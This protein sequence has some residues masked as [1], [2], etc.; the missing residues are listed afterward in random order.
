MVFDI[1]LPYSEE[2]FEDFLD[3]IHN[4]TSVPSAG[5]VCDIC[6]SLSCG[7][8]CCESPC[9]QFDD[10][11]CERVLSVLI[12]NQKNDHFDLS[13]YESSVSKKIEKFLSKEN[14]CSVS[15]PSLCRIFGACN[16]TFSLSSLKPFF[17]GCTKRHGIGAKILLHCIQYKKPSDL[18]D[19]DQF[20]Q[21]MT[22]EDSSGIS[23]NTNHFLSSFQR[24]FESL[25]IENQRNMESNQKT[26]NELNNRIQ[27]HKSEILSSK[28]AINE[29]NKE[30]Q[31]RDSII[32]EKSRDILE[33]EKVLNQNKCV[34][35]EKE[36]LIK[37]NIAEIQEKDRIIKQK[38]IEIQDKE[39]KINEQFKQIMKYTE[40]VECIF[41]N[42]L[43]SGI[44]DRLS[45]KNSI[46]LAESGEVVIAVSSVYDND[47]SQYNPYHVLQND[48]TKWT[49][50]SL[51]NS[52]IQFD[53]RKRKV[54]IT[55]YSLN[56][57]SLKSWRVEGSPDGIEFEI[58]DN[59]VDCLSF[60]K[61]FGNYNDN[62]SRDN[63]QV[64]FTNKYYQYIRITS[65]SNCWNRFHSSFI[66]CRVEFFGSI[67]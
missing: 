33:K 3:M 1:D 24:E 26:V 57:N 35:N 34:I 52:W 39:R 12:R 56:V 67:N 58:I 43:F 10:D 7:F 20:L 22:I 63:F 65:T 18:S 13:L 49:S 9:Q 66:L 51:P 6:N 46:N 29:L 4:K 32:S 64:K 55:S 11:S 5:D 61:S 14:F 36:N 31:K 48:D 62:N 27:E 54:S 42:D 53:F 44:F 8:L 59:R 23:D 16:Q 30:I 15:L 45:E 50:K 17:I 41:R 25:R 2:S 37:L 40:K 38:T 60:Q 19:L 47:Y 21:I 28:T